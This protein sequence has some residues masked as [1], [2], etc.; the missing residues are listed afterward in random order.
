MN[1]RWGNLRAIISGD[2]LLARASEIAASLGTE[3]AGLLAATIGQLC[4][5][6]V[7][8]LATAF[9][10]DR[11]EES[12][13]ASIERKT[14]SLFGAATRIGAIVGGLPPDDI[15]RLSR[16]GT[17]YGIV[18]QMIDDLLDI[19]A[20]DEQLGK[21]AGHD[22]IEGVYTLPVL[23]ALH[24]PEGG[25]LRELLGVPIAGADWARARELVRSSRG[26]AETI[27]TARSYVRWAIDELEPL[28]HRPAA[29]ALQKSAA[30]LV[31]TLDVVAEPQLP[32]RG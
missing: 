20:T 23:R 6:E 13:L 7:L 14:A 27:E 21:P 3:V 1:A 10:P 19:V 9:Q 31:H 26:I 16:F 30:H 11:S 15:D 24:G 5:G 18:F 29:R 28:A 8:E 32:R 22:L 25:E 17:R 4:E 2:L 12:Y